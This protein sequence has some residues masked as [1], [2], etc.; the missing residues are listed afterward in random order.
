MHQTPKIW[1]LVVVGLAALF[2]AGC[3]GEGKKRPPLGKV[4]GTV[5]YKGKPV[6]GAAVSFIMER[7]PRGATGTT[8]VEGNYKL[9]TFDTFDGAFV[10]T[11][12][13][14]VVKVDPNR[15]GKESKDNAPEDLAKMMATGNFEPNETKAKFDELPA[16]YADVNTTPLQYTIEAGENEKKIELE[17]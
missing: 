17:D 15:A 5:T 1:S 7:A 16:K 4:K 6:S 11:H 13:V 12:K 2:V 8:D 14:T 10:G 3:A 9:T